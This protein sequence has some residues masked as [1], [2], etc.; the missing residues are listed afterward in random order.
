MIPN[1]V[2]LFVALCFVVFLLV[3]LAMGTVWPW[4]VKATVIIA[5]VGILIGCYFSLVQLLGWPSP[6]HALEKDK[7]LI[8]AV[9]REPD[10]RSGKDGAIFLWL[11]SLDQSLP[12]R[13]LKLPYSRQS[14]M[15][16]IEALKRQNAGIKQGI[17][18]QNAQLGT[19]K[20]DSFRIYDLYKPK[21]SD[22]Q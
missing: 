19:G 10:T 9:V 1:L 17:Q 21:P 16:I 6:F 13:A 22:K 2:V 4:I 20:T 5:S 7:M 12:P 3:T 15:T 18:M 11:D 8:H 14:H